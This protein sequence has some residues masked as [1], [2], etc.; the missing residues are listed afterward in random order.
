MFGGMDKL[1]PHPD[2]L[3][4]CEQRDALH[5]QISAVLT[6]MHVL[7]DSRGVVLGQY[8]AAFAPRLTEL[9]R[10]EIEAARMKREIE[11]IQAA[12]NSGSDIDYEIIQ[13][14][15]E[16]EFAA[17]QARLD[18][19]AVELAASQ[20]VLAHLLDPASARVLREKFR[21]LARRL[22]PDLHPGQSP[23]DAALWH[24]VT[25]AYDNGDVDGIISLEI[26]TSDTGNPPPD[27]S[28][29]CLRDHVAGLRAQLDR[30]LL[31]LEARRNVWPFDQ[32]PLLDDPDALASRQL[33]LDARIGE[34]RVLHDQRKHWLAMLLDHP[35]R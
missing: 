20:A 7:A 18:D 26:I 13:S 35:T 12:N 3:S 30:L 4:L 16:A 6:D 23:E 27:G 15:L 33:E 17:W 9:H 22:H 28:I 5:S 14:T 31:A 2:W 34:A 11:L 29:D 25:A 10:L 19:E 21:I 1:V 32:I 8:A 24:R